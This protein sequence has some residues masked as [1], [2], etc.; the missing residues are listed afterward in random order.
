MKFISCLVIP[1]GIN[2][3]TQK[4][5]LNI[6]DITNLPLYR[7][8]TINS[9]TTISTQAVFHVVHCDRGLSMRG[10]NE[11]PPN[12][13]RSSLASLSR[14][15]NMLTVVPVLPVNGGPAPLSHIAR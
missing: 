12:S 15:K 14:P 13:T 3:S 10:M 5:I 1:E 11:W 6:K 8:P 9:T 4:Y 2:K 7:P